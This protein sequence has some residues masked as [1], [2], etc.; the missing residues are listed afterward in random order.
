MSISFRVVSDVAVVSIP[1]SIPFEKA[2]SLALT[3]CFPALRFIL[4]CIFRGRSFIDFAP[5]SIA[6]SL[7]YTSGFMIGI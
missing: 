3:A 1:K 4:F 5:N 7:A 6:N 2:Y